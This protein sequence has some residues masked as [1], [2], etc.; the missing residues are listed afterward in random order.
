MRPH[1]DD[2]ERRAMDLEPAPDLRI[3]ALNVNVDVNDLLDRF[4]GSE[5]RVFEFLGKLKDLVG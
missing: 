4:D 1:P 3:P 2:I 5:E